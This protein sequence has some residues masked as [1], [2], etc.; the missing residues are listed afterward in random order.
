MKAVF[1]FSHA[2]DVL[3]KMFDSSK[4]SIMV[5]FKEQLMGFVRVSRRS[6]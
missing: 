2:L 5:A 4:K 1:I 3:F 6:A